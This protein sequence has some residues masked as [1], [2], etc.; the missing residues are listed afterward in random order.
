MRIL[1]VFLI[2]SLLPIISFG[3]SQ[4]DN[5]FFGSESGLEF[6]PTN[7]SISN[8]SKIEATIGCTSFSDVNRQVLFYSNGET[9]WNR[10]NEVMENGNN[11]SGETSCLL[12]TSPSPRDRTRSRM[13]SSA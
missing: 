11:L 4:T 12:Y 6:S 1:I 9:V 13:P 5:W 8:G 10:N 7:V 3:Q 2:V